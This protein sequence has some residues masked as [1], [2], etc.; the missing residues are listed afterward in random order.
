MYQKFNVLLREKN[1]IGKVKKHKYSLVSLL[2]Q[3]RWKM[4]ASQSKHKGNK[5]LENLLRNLLKHKDKFRLENKREYCLCAY[6]ERAYCYAHIQNVVY[7]Y[8]CIQNLC[9]VMHTYRTCVLLCTHTERSVLLCTHT[10]R[11]VLLCTHTERSVFLCTHTER[12]V[13]L[14]THTERSVLTTPLENDRITFIS[15]IWM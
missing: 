4:R 3:P 8:A 13:L 1:F 10:E 9:I 5:I 7:C 6:T 15:G 14:C 2:R 12:S 11:S